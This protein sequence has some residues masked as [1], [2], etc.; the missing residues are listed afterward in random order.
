MKRKAK[1]QETASETEVARAAW[2]PQTRRL[3]VVGLVLAFIVLVYW[4][5]ETLDSLIIAALLAYLLNPLVTRLGAMAR[6]PRIAAAALVYLAL[7]ALLAVGSFTLIPIAVRQVATLGASLDDL[8]QH[9]GEL[10]AQYPQLAAL[11]VDTATLAA[12]VRAELAA[13]NARVPS[14]LVGAASSVFALVFVLVM[15]FY[16]LKDADKF[17][18]ALLNSITPPHRDDAQKIIADL[19]QIWSSFLRGQVMLAIVI[20]TLTTAVLWVLGVRNALLLGLLAGVLEVV[21]TIGPIIAMVPA[22][23]IALLQGSTRWA[24]DPVI[25]ALV[26]V[27]AYLVIQQLENNLIVP[28]VLGESVNLPGV[29]ILFGAFAGAALA[30][31]LGIFLAAPVLATARVFLAFVFRKLQEPVESA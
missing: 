29:V 15:A 20:G 16:L 22:V 10:A 9:A 30:G 23:V 12:R 26:V 1:V 4:V 31:I 19:D 27:G 8:A 17:E 3:I 7:L 6:M 21:P 24:L 18:D 13:L 28:K 5:R 2:S 11:G 25:F 14:L